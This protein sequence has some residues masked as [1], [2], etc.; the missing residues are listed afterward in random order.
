[1]PTTPDY[2]TGKICYLEIPCADPRAAARFYADAFGWPLRE[3]GDGAIAFDDAVGQVSGTWVTG[4]SPSR[5]PG[6]VVHVMVGQIGPV[7]DRVRAGGGAI[8]R[9]VDPAASEVYA[10]VRDPYGNVLGVYQQPG[11]AQTEGVGAGSG[12][13]RPVDPVP[14]QLHTVNLR[15]A[16][17]RAAEAIDFYTRAFGA[18]ETT[19][20]FCEPG[21]RI[22]HTEL[23]IGDTL[24]HVT[25]DD[26]YRAL[27][28]TYWPDLDAV[29]AR[30]V[31]AGATVLHPL[32]DQFY[33]E[34]G[35]RL[36]DPFGQQWMLSMRTEILSHEE[37]LERARAEMG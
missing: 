27:L 28:H 5:E 19:E 33:G 9:D 3:R 2:A 11:L 18:R 16:V 29:W 25:E 30:A 20:R 26:G 31:A 21:G 22:I 7:L 32:A 35:G 24:V 8:V 10:H 13:G 12:S 6:I 15:L 36:Q 34:R 1:M 37:M 23:E 14:E 17:P 4:R